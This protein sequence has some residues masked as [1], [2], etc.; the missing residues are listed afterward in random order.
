MIIS[1]YILI[2]IWLGI[3]SLI[4]MFGRFYREEKIFCVWEKRMIP[5]F[6]VIAILPIIWLA[7]N[8]G[9]IMDTY[10]Y[11]IGFR[12]MPSSLSEMANYIPTVKKDKGFTVLS[13]VI[14]AIFGSNEI[15]Y[16]L[17]LAGIQGFALW[18]VYRKYSESYLLSL[19]LF[20]A[21]TDFM[22][23]MCNGLRQ[24]MAVT[25]IFSVTTLM[26]KK[27]YFPVIA[28]I[29]LASTFH[30]TALLMIPCVFIA[31]GKAWNKRTLLFTAMVLLTVTYVDQF[32]NIL[33]SA[34]Y[35]TQY[36]NVVSDWTGWN[37][38]GTN[39]LRVLVYS[40]P[41][42]IAVVGRKYIQYE[43]NPIINFCV[44]MSVISTGL[45]LISMVTSGI[46]IGRLPIYASL[47]NYIL[48]PWEINHFFT[49]SSAKAVKLLVIVFYLAFYYF[50]MHFVWGYI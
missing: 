26:L 48:L 1:E 30:G 4:Q 50:Q 18:V 37:D 28:V 13:I 35:D 44:N 3:L 11:L 22:S 46:F 12:Q 40:L 17:I 7:A 32:T 39:P 31:Q 10:M 15:I 47:Y 5:L 20:M 34:L 6:A 27:K 42:I 38:D 49:E 25:V 43:D 21:S 45:Y 29:L 24:F 8:R 36:A 2:I 23:W 19:F 16:L 33:D 41:T 9:T 14:K